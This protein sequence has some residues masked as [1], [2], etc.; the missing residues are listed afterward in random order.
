MSLKLHD[1][2]SQVS[3]RQRLLHRGEISLYLKQQTCKGLRLSCVAQRLFLYV[4]RMA[5]IP[6]GTF[7]SNI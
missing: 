1:L 4:E 7:A 3:T 2:E 6:K 5:E